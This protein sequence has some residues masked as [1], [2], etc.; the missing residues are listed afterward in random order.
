MI[1]TDDPDSLSWHEFPYILLLLLV[2][3]VH[4]LTLRAPH[5]QATVRLTPRKLVPLLTFA[6]IQ[7]VDGFSR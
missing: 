7:L 5:S 6:R 4:R 3:T 1:L 2:R